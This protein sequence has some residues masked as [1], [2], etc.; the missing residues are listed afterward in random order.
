MQNKP[1]VRSHRRTVDFSGKGQNMAYESLAASYDRLTNDVPYAAVLAFYDEILVRFG[2]APKTALDLACGT[3]SMAILLA[4]RGLSVLGADRSEEMLTEASCKAAEMENPPYFIHQSMERLR[5][6]NPVDLCVCC[7]DGVNY[8]TEPDK[9]AEAFRRVKK[10]LT[11]GG[12]FI[13]DVNSEAKL[14]G[15]D[16]QIFLDEDDHVFC[17]WRAMF[18]EATRIC[19]YGMD[20]FRRLP[21][22]KTAPDAPRTCL[23]EALWDRSREEHLER[24]YSVAELTELLRGAGFETVEVYGDRRLEPPR[25]DE[26]RIFF[27][28]R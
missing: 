21:L 15:L 27:A 9:L 11:P 12:L 25:P 14:R 19:T 5:L 8:V 3:G 24:A 6:P 28:A 16:G 22:P 26:Q 10:N 2:A 18:D 23:P 13:F 17:L 4:E 1:T 7:L 20:I